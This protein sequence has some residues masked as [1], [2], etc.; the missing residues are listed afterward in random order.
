[1][2]YDQRL[3][4]GQA[5]SVIFHSPQTSD[6]VGVRPTRDGHRQVVCEVDNERRV[7]LHIV[8]ASVPDTSI[9][10]ALI[11]GVA[12]RN[13]MAGVFSALRARKIDFEFPSD[14]RTEGS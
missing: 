9:A 1:M 8:D 4:Q 11:E 14:A 6:F 10:E 2:L 7:L 3:E 13:L 5:I 12:A